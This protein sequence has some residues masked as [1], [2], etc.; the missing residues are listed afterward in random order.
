MSEVTNDSKI[1]EGLSFQQ[2]FKTAQEAETAAVQVASHDD[3]KW[4]K[5]VVINTSASPWGEVLGY[6]VVSDQT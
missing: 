3:V 1:R 5:V 2:G 4:V 6:I